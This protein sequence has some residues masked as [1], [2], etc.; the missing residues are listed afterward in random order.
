MSS[1]FPLEIPK[2]VDI[3]CHRKVREATPLLLLAVHSPNI[4]MVVE[5]FAK[6]C[7]KRFNPLSPGGTFMVQIIAKTSPI[8]IS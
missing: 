5:V 2:P 3:E 6:I 8:S 4:T 7:G 1:I